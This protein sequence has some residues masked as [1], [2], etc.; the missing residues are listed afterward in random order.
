VPSNGHLLVGCVRQYCYCRERKYCSH[1]DRN[2]V[3]YIIKVKEN[4]PELLRKALSRLPVDVVITGDQ[5]PAEK[6][7][8][9]RAAS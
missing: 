4:T 3:S 5:Q 8:K 7:L 9:S 2:D 6:S 1:D